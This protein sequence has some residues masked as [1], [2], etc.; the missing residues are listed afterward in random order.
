MRLFATLCLLLFQ[1]QVFAAGT[2]TCVHAGQH[3][4][5]TAGC[6]HAPGGGAPGTAA[7]AGDNEGDRAITPCQKCNLNLC[8]AGWHLLPGQPMALSPMDAVIPAPLPGRHFYLFS[9]DGL[10]KPPI[11]ISG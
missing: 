11:P 1:L 3:D 8:A 10:L 5:A 6:P 2:L 9:P 4:M 7:P